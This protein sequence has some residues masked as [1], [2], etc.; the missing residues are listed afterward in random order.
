MTAL[1]EAVDDQMSG[2]PKKKKG[3]KTASAAS[4]VASLDGVDIDLGDLKYLD[5]GDSDSDESFPGLNA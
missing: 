3:G 1:E 4:N 5:G 2:K